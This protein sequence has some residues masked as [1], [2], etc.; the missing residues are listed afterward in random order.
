MVS[1]RHALV[2]TIC[3]A[4]LLTPTQ[5][6][7]AEP[8]PSEASETPPST[9]PPSTPD[10]PV[11]SIGDASEDELH[12]AMVKAFVER[13]QEGEFLFN[14]G[15]YIQAA[16]EFE[17]AF[18]TIPAEAAL[19]NAVLSYER[20]GDR[21]S[22]ALAARRYLALPPCDTP[23]IDK[24]KCSLQIDKLETQYERLMGQIGQ[25]ELKIATGVVLSEISINNR[26]VAIADF[27]V[28]VAPG[29]IDVELVG[30]SPGQRRQRFIDVRQGETQTINVGPFDEPDPDAPPIGPRRPRERPQWLK[31][32]FW[33][34]LG[35]TVGSGIAMATMGGLFLRESRLYDEGY[36]DGDPMTPTPECTGDGDQYPHEHERRAAKYQLTTNALIGVTAGLALVTLVI[37]AV[38]FTGPQSKRKRNGGTQ[39]A[40]TRVRW[41]G[42]GVLVRW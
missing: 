40:S 29:R 31:P 13:F 2:R 36:C 16:A 10:E 26:K 33:S 1:L 9:A 14:R 6:I 38:A 28:L 27:P 23:D 17:R 35:I 3:A 41:T 4:S 8:E 30:A 21:V 7:A 20:G 12:E 34:G 19:A 18:A 15:Q 24:A 25:L 32:L 42:S 37:G 22:A 5:V 39:R 11:R